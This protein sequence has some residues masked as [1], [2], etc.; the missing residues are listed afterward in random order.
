MEGDKGRV[1]ERGGEYV[2]NILKISIFHEPST[3]LS[4]PLPLSPFVQNI[5]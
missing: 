3:L 4:P 2:Q 5:T 1:E